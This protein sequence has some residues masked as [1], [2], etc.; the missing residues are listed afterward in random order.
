MRF[1]LTVVLGLLLAACSGAPPNSAVPSQL[2]ERY[3]S[4]SATTSLAAI[5]R[6]HNISAPDPASKTPLLEQLVAELAKSDPNNLYRGITYGL[7]KGN[8]LERDWIV[9][10]PNVWGRK[11]SDLP[12]GHSAELVQRLRDLIAGAR[13]S[14]DITL[15][16]PVPD[17]EI[18]AALR[19]GLAALAGRGQ[20]ID[21]RILIGQYPPDDVDAAAFL[22]S[23]AVAAPLSVH[24]A[25]MRSCMAGEPCD[26]FS[27]NHAK[28]IAVDGR[29]AFVG[30]HNLWPADYLGD[31]PVFDLS[32]VVRG[33]AADA[34]SRFADELWDFS[35]RSAN[36]DKAV[37][38]VSSGV[39]LCPRAF[40]GEKVAAS[41]KLDVVSIGRLGVGIAREFA[42]HSE[43]ARD[44]M[45]GA[46][47]KVIRIAQQD[48][49]FKLGRSD[50][51]F[52]ESAFERLV[53]FIEQGGEIYIVLSNEGALGNSGSTYSNE[54]P[55]EAV[56]RRLH[57]MVTKHFE[58]LNQRGM[59]D[60]SPKM[61]PD[62]VNALLCS[63][64]HIAPFRF[65]PD[66]KWPSGSPFALHA[67][68]WMVDDRAFYFG[69]DNLYPVNLQEFGY[70]V[71]DRR[72]AQE[73]L[74]AWWNPMWQ[75]SAPAAVSGEGVKRCVFRELVPSKTTPKQ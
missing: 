69:S 15:L 19:D 42:N 37:Q 28:I 54:V 65:G 9:Q 4:R 23:L 36:K 22:Q 38:V 56:A 5:V 14:I 49:G 60:Q 45:F 10:T 6:D 18:L 2:A 58:Q 33:P 35:C 68:F 21:V 47:R 26:G 17:K 50:M 16:E 59:V 46:A 72:A 48:L 40:A 41:G 75:W 12:P 57:Q 30:G 32:M 34:A 44:L 55:I 51:L 1:G 61:G 27:W 73:I 63:R 62:P 70:I 43:L 67:K 20:P 29:V 64:V 74:D 52:P 7:T 39:R 11:A 71:D 24:V 66:D 31:R 25:A 53:A 8:S 3:Y 13:R